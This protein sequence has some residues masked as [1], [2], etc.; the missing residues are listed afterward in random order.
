MADNAAADPGIEDD[1]QFAD[2]RL[3]GVQPR[4]RARAGAC[5]DVGDAF[6][7]GQM[8]RAVP[9]VIA[10]HVRAFAR[11]GARRKAV[12]ARPL[13]PKKAMSPEARSAGKE[14]VSTCISR[15]ATET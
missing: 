6:E 4:D 11:D 1:R 2:R 7:V 9:A 12:P 15:G 10:L 13:T 8:M 3:A 14:G 5:P